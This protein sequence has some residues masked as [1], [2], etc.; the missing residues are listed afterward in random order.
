[1]L[2]L[3]RSIPYL[4]ISLIPG[5]FFSTRALNAHDSNLTPIIYGPQ[6][7]AA[8]SS[9]CTQVRT[10]ALMTSLLLTTSASTFALEW[11]NSWNRN[12]KDGCIMIVKCAFTVPASPI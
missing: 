9:S 12:R 8:R 3:P 4:K 6:S 2:C 5:T 1:M 7:M 11:A 10:P